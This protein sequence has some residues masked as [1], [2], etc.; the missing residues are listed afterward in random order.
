MQY[1]LASLLT[2]QCCVAASIGSALLLKTYLHAHICPLIGYHLTALA[3]L[4]M[5]RM[6]RVAI[7]LYVPGIL[8][9][10][11]GAFGIWL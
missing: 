7:C 2:W 1:R 5:R 10:V 4:T 3:L 8:L 11:C 6:P 9:W